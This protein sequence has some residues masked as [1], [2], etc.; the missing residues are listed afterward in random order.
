MIESFLP[1]ASFL[2]LYAREIGSSVPSGS[3]SSPFV[4]DST[5]RLSG[6]LESTFSANQSIPKEGT[7]DISKLQ[8]SRAESSSS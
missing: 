7:P 3:S 2:S 4:T 8:F 1:G 5:T 6:I